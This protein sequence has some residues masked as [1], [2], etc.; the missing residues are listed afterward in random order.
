VT[1][2]QPRRGEGRKKI[3]PPRPADRD[4]DDDF[5]RQ[6]FRRFAQL[7]G[8]EAF[9]RAQSCGRPE[10]STPVNGALSSPLE[11]SSM[12]TPRS[13]SALVTSR[14]MP[15]R[16]LPR[17]S[18]LMRRDGLSADGAPCSIRTCSPPFSSRRSDASSSAAFVSGTLTSTMPANL[19][20]RSAEI[21]SG[22]RARARYMAAPCDFPGCAVSADQ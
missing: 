1:V 12:L 17:M 6:L 3:S 9:W 18:S 8:G 5:G 19:P 2:G 20:A 13:V 15:G 7:L 22:P 21:D 16:S 11:N 10:H 4:I 14:T